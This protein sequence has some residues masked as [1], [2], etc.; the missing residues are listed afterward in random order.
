LTGPDFEVTAKDESTMYAGRLK[1]GKRHGLGVYKTS[2]FE[3]TGSW[4][5][6]KLHGKDCKIVYFDYKS[7]I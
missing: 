2:E 4:D 7:K 1:N 6:D 3:K 5:N